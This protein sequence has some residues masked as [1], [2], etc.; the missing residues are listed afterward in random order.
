MKRCIT[1]FLLCAAALGL[2]AGCSSDEE[3]ASVQPVSMCVD[4]GAM[5]AADRYAGKV[6]SGETAA[7][8]RDPD[9][10]VLEIYVEVG[11]MVEEGELLFSYDT[12][13]LQLDLD[14]LY[15]ERES[16]ENTISAAKTEIEELESQRASASSSQQLSYTLQI[17][18]READIREAE[19]NLLLKEREITAMEADMENTDIASPLAGRVMTVNDDAGENA[20]PETGESGAFITVMDVSSYRIEGRINEL[21]LAALT[22]GAEVVIHSRMDDTVWH[23]TVDFID[24]ENPI[25]GSNNSMVIMDSGDEMT[26]TSKYPFYVALEDTAGLLLG[27]H[28]YIEPGAGGDAAGGLML[29]EFY[30]SDVEGEP[31]VWAASERDTLEKRA[32][33]LGAYDE[34]AGQ[35]EILSGLTL[36]DYIAFPEDRLFA[37]MALVYMDESSFGGGAESE[38]LPAGDEVVL[39]EPFEAEPAPMEVG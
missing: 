22:E 28:V 36:R 24:W 12:E 1:V 16:Y 17:N 30:I 10:T 25:T 11:D 37:G 13:A 15:L 20:D 21:N 8:K 34:A 18:T 38:V 29:P 14:K 26:S 9:K 19:Y 5:S 27:Q 2:A 7:I 35:Y 39:S 4:Q 23:G 3:T 33:T 32:V 6:V 31:W